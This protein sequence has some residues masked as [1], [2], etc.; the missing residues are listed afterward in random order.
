LNLDKFSQGAIIGFFHF[1]REETGWK[2]FLTPVV[3]DAF[4]ADSFAATWLP[5]AVTFLDIFFF[6]TFPH[7]QLP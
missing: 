3:L 4:T 7:S 5:G 6:L 2:L 1:L